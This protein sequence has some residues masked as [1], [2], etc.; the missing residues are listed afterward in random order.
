VAAGLLA[1]GLLARLLRWIFHGPVELPDWFRWAFALPVALALV[2][3]VPTILGI[4]FQMRH[5]TVPLFGILGILLGTAALWHLLR[6][7]ADNLSTVVART[8]GAADDI[9]LSLAIAAARTG[10]VIAAALGIAQFLSISPT[11]ILAGLGIGGLAVAFASR[12]TLSN[13]FGAGILVTDRPFKRGDWITSGDISGAVE[14]V[15]IRST[16]LRTAQGSMV[17]VPNG[18]LADSGIT[19]LGEGP[20]RTVKAQLLV[21]AGGSAE[22]IGRFARALRRRIQDDAAFLAAKTLVQVDGLTAAGVELSLV[23][24]LA[25]DAPPGAREALLLDAIRL[26]EAEGM[27]LGAGL[28]PATAAAA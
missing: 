28:A 10:L 25:L 27:T 22:R 4:P 23:T 26:A 13:V 8:W 21:T 3:P 16:R 14:H 1:A 19:N 17:V 18:K 11:G 15:G 2:S 12:E 7:V 20:A 6:V 9:L 5:Y 24:Q